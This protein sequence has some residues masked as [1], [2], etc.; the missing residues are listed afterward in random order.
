MVGKTLI[1]FLGIFWIRWSLLRFRS[2]Q[3]MA[4]C[5]RWLIP[6]SLVLVMAAAVWVY[7]QQQ[8]GV[9]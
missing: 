7:Y 8:L 4:L 1:L 5:W 9:S 6:L 3:L 2:D